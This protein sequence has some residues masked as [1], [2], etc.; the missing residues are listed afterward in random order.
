[1][2][3]L[4]SLKFDQNLYSICLYSDITRF[5]LLMVPLSYRMSVLQLMQSDQSRR[6]TT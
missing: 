3:A 5:G 2:P 6:Q 1:M 4:L